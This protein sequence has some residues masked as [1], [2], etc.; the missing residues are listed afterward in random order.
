[1]QGSKT[2]GNGRENGR[3]KALPAGTGLVKAGGLAALVTMGL[4]CG[5]LPFWRLRASASAPLLQAT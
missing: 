3:M 4:L 2:A 5:C 1:M